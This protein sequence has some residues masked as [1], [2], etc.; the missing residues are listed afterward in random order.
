MRKRMAGLLVLCLFLTG[1]AKTEGDK[2]TTGDTETEKIQIGMSL[3]SFVVERWQRDRDIFVSTAK[4]LG[5]EVNVQNANGDV[6]EQIAQLEYF[7]EKNLDVIVVVPI[8]AGSLKEV[9]KS[10][11][12]AGIKVICYDR[13]AVDSNADLYISFDNTQVGRLM[14]ME[15]KEEIGDAGEVIMI[16]GSEQDKN[17]EYVTKGFM[18]ALK[19]SEIKVSDTVYAEGW[20]PEYAAEYINEHLEQVKNVKAIMCGNDSL[21]GQAI[22]ALTENRLAGQ[23][24]VVG[25]DA[26]LDACQRIVEG[27]QQMTVYKPVEKLA[28]QAARAAV[29][30]AL[31]ESL[32]TKDTIMDG[33]YYIPYIK[34]EPVGV[35]Q[36]NLDTA[37]IDS[38]F[39]LREDVY[40]Y[41]PNLAEK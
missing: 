37:I 30:L 18:S 39:H 9:I 3:D 29:K 22:K 8:E 16:C 31:G 14:G 5:A 25:Q 34:L 28:S 10:A 36:D 1:C 19:D 20:R 12:S 24:Y 41:R 13:L 7:I 23:V 6:K 21:A 2:I 26:D 27:T 17:V 38:G 11:K 33:M 40:R 4:E 35:T 15:L 32:E